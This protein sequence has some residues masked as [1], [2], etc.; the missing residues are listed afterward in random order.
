MTDYRAYIMGIDGHRFVKAAGFLSDYPDDTAALKAA[1]RLVDGH[2]VELWDCSRLVARMGH[3]ST[4]NAARGE[5]AKACG[6]SAVSVNSEDT[7]RLADESPGLTFSTEGSSAAGPAPQ[8]P[9]PYDQK[10][11]P[12]SG[13][14]G[15]WRPG[16][17]TVST[18]A[19]LFR[20][21]V[22]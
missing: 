12:T 19:R 17:R 3:T 20:R 15:G 21:G 11:S 13:R 5:K 10:V 16:R 6:S 18:I 8:T 7:P 9:D 2:D 22:G 14:H 4:A 1:E